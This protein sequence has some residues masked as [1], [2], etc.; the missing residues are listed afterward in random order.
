MVGMILFALLLFGFG[1]AAVALAVV[2][3]SLISLVWDEAGRHDLTV[4]RWMKFSCGYLAAYTVLW[5]VS[6]DF[7]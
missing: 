4:R 6:V 1:A 5:W 7:I 2:A 3:A